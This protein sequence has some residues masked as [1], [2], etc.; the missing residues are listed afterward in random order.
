VATLA[1]V[2]LFELLPPERRPEL[3]VALCT[4]Q[5]IAETLP[6]LEGALRGKAKVESVDV[7]SG[8]DAEAVDRFLNSMVAVAKHNTDAAITVDIT[9]GFRHFS[10][11]MYV[12]ALYLGALRRV[13]VDA[14]Y[15]APF[16]PELPV[17]P[18]FDLAPLLELP[19]WIHALETL[20]ETG[21]AKG[22]ANLLRTH[23]SASPGKEAFSIAR[24]MDRVSDAHG[25]GLPIELGREVGM[26]F[27]QKERP[28]VPYL[29]TWRTFSVRGTSAGKAK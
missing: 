7:P 21:S 19:R 3:V 10:F 14:I 9:H 1:P 8:A 11:L 23:S 29:R 25:A 27:V 6:L 22:I 20:R 18:F 5:A 24:I 12:G 26:F 16:S 15:Y 2:T 13:T 4:E 28:S 17:S